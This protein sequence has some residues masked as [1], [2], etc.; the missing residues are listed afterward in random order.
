[1]SRLGAKAC[2]LL[3]RVLLPARGRHRAVPAAP[4]CRCRLGAAQA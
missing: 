1:M 3:L 2:E 4:R